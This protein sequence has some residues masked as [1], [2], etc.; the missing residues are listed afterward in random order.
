MGKATELPRATELIPK[1]THYELEETW[2]STQPA[3][4]M[5]YLQLLCP[6]VMCRLMQKIGPIRLTRKTWYE[7]KLV[8]RGK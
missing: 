3:L 4:F 8:L 5:A 2:T 6:D 7:W 1:S